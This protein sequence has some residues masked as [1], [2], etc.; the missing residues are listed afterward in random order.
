MPTISAITDR[1]AVEVNEV[2]DL[3]ALR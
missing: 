2:D 3:A 1:F